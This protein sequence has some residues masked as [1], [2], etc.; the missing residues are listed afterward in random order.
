M[1]RTEW[2][3]NTEALV[4]INA[5][6]ITRRMRFFPFAHPY[7]SVCH[8]V[9]CVWRQRQPWAAEK[10]RCRWRRQQQTVVKSNS[11]H[12]S[13]SHRSTVLI[14]KMH[15]IVIDKF[16]SLRSVSLAHSIDFFFCV[17]AC[18]S[19]ESFNHSQTQSVSRDLYTEMIHILC[20]TIHCVVCTYNVRC[21]HTKC[22]CI[23][24]CSTIFPAAVAAAV[25]IFFASIFSLIIFV[26]HFFTFEFCVAKC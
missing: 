7:G 2:Q 22:I 23:F 16:Y 24:K 13:F 21:T 12:Y 18:F 19:P 4:E 17:F 26:C 10:W 9:H 14:L 25:A 6:Q 8:T 1:Y 20:L 15:K 3:R 11:L 5:R